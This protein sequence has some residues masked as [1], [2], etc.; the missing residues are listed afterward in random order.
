MIDT[1]KNEDISKTVDVP[2]ESKQDPQVLPKT[3]KSLA[4]APYRRTR[5]FYCL[6]VSFQ[7]LVLTGLAS[8]KA[9]TLAYGR[10]VTLRTVPVDPRD[11]FRGD[12]VRLN[13][14]ISS[15]PS[16]KDFKSGQEVYVV[17]KQGDKYWSAERI[18][19]QLPVLDSE[20]IAL[21][22]KIEWEHPQD[23]W[24]VRYG[25]EQMFVEEGTGKNL[26]QSKH[27]R[28]DLAV[29]KF[30]NSVVKSAERE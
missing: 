18:A 2:S 12:Y 7:L 3:G 14:E 25:I 8:V 17:L 23:V 24:H 29:D 28:V 10:T 30:G 22:G 9:Y 27:L 5:M 11:I 6:A 19:E 26:E 13:Y 20:Q 15:V 1:E 4:E 16:K 21:K